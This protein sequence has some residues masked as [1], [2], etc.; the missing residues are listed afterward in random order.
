MEGV[1][2]IGLI[3][4][5]LVSRDLFNTVL[6]VLDTIEAQSQKGRASASFQSYLLLIGSDSFVDVWHILN[7]NILYDGS[8]SDYLLQL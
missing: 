6:Q 2:D 5:D 1:R 7:L 3:L 4:S 8:R